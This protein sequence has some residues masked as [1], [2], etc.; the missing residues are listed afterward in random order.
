[1]GKIKLGK[2][3]RKV[4][5]MT[6]RE[7]PQ[8]EAHSQVD[9][10]GPSGRTGCW[11]FYLLTLIT[12]IFFLFIFPATYALLLLIG[13]LV[14]AVFLS[15]R[16]AEFSPRNVLTMLRTTVG[17]NQISRQQIVAFVAEHRIGLR[18]G[19]VL[20][21]IGFMSLSALRF[22][23]GNPEADLA[24][25][26]FWSLL[27]VMA[28]GIAMAAQKAE[29]I[30]SLSESSLSPDHSHAGIT[31]S[32]IVLLMT[33]AEINGQVLNLP[34]LRGITLDIQFLVFCA[35]ISLLVWGFSGAAGLRI[36]KLRAVQWRLIMPVISVFLLALLLRSW[37]LG[38]S[39]NGLVDEALAIDHVF[40]AESN[41]TSAL[42]E[43]LS[44]FSS[45]LIY[46]YLE[47]KVV[48]LIGHNFAGLRATSALIGSLNIV[49]LY[50]L[51]EALF[52][53]KTAFI[54]ALLLTV[55]PPHIHF[56]RI[57]IANIADPLFGTL[58]LA[59]M[60]R[61]IKSNR[62]VDWTAA[63]AAL[64]LTQ[65]FFEGGRLFFPP[66]LVLWIVMLILCLSF[67]R[68]QILWRGMVVM[69]LTVMFVGMPVYYTI[70]ARDVSRIARLE[71]SGLDMNYWQQ[72]LSGEFHFGKIEELFQRVSLPFQVYV[73]RPENGMY[74]GGQEAMILAYLVPAFLLGTAY[75]FWRWKS[76]I[77]IVLLWLIATPLGNSLLRESIVYARYTVVFP[78]I[79]LTI[80]VALR[81]VLAM[82]WRGEP[83]RSYNLFLLLITA[84]IGIAQVQYYFGVHL[85][86]F[87]HSLR[88]SKPYRD[89]FDA[90]MRTADLP[91]NIKIYIVS[92]P[93]NDQSTLRMLLAFLHTS[94]DNMTVSTLLTDELTADFLT[95]LP[96]NENYAFF[97]EPD[98]DAIVH[99]LSQFFDLGEPQLSPYPIPHDKEYLLY[100]IP[101]PENNPQEQGQ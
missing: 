2:P 41:R 12:G 27:G 81:Y 66:L 53:R 39:I 5:E 86:A 70:F 92:N 35:G 87:N 14:A 18:I 90:I 29:P 74:Y 15:A 47:S 93:A 37:N 61:G 68:L 57:A 11:S 85:A 100:Y 31:L 40:V 25:G 24:V 67:K 26:V 54:A 84:A 89:G 65:Y 98:N 22:Q 69:F 82:L 83:R 8:P 3:E 49:A 72:L 38:T 52:D 23:S 91:A 20:L 21:A 71:V 94:A 7:N 80:A 1:M 9:A 95:Q 99:L 44:R 45:T 62:R 56:S 63:G 48:G 77:C 59:F 73:H 75:I 36:P 101:A 55:F 51:A 42:A 60:A 79:A 64:G 88:D 58:A 50:L 30:I 17:R 32:G 97:V 19:G 4:L 33:F 43:P 96:A 76:P 78:A 16:D 10:D 34:F 13:L 6:E 28:L 46:S